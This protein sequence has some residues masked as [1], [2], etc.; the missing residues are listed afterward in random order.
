MHCYQELCKKTVEHHPELV[1][2]RRGVAH[3]GS[4]LGALVRIARQRAVRR[5]QRR[6]L[7]FSYAPQPRSCP[8][9]Y[10]RA[11]KHRPAAWK[12]G[13]VARDVSVSVADK[14]EH[15]PWQFFSVAPLRHLLLY[16]QPLVASGD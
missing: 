12:P 11:C 2:R 6:G 1:R 7:L 16:M 3:P 13:N 14:L 15:R 4:L 5:L 8:H 9:R 10:I